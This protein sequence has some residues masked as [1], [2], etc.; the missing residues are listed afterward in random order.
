MKGRGQA[1][2]VRISE[3]FADQAR[4]LGDCTE[5]RLPSLISSDMRDVNMTPKQI[6]KL[7]ASLGFTQQQLADKLGTPQPTVARWESGTTKPHRLYVE[8][9]EEL[10]KTVKKDGLTRKTLLQ[11]PTPGRAT[12]G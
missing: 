11:E 7:R 10:K 2:C 4:P 6:V 12:S 3:L 5:Y 8:K 9:L 1:R